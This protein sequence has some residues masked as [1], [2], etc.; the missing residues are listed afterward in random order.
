[1]PNH[2]VFSNYKNDG[3]LCWAINYAQEWSYC[4]EWDTLELSK[5]CSLV[6][7]FVHWCF[8]LIILSQHT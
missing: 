6:L 5:S 7:T 1:M 8:L 4:L 2:P 3:Q